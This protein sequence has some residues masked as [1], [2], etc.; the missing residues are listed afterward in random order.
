MSENVQAGCR[1]YGA[2]DR[3]V[4][5]PP[6]SEELTG[7]HCTPQNVETEPALPMA[8]TPGF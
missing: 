3:E 2:E 1:E 6:S 5:D 8:G 4:L 7:V